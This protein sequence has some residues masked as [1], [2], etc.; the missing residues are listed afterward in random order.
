MN[1]KQA[2]QNALN[3][4]KLNGYKVT[5]NQIREG[6]YCL[7]DDNGNSLTGF[8]NFEKINHFI[9]GY[10]KARHQPKAVYSINNCSYLFKAKAYEKQGEGKYI[11]IMEE[12]NESK[13]FC[14]LFIAL[15]PTRNS[16][17]WEQPIT[18][19]KPY[20]MANIMEVWANFEFYFKTLTNV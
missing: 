4:L 17:F 14:T 13:I 12:D 11:N 8:W 2:L 6:Q 16:I 7:I 1:E 9:L 3:S 10:G 5:Q 15:F 19:V 18:E 20:Q